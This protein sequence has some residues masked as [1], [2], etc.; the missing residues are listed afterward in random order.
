MGKNERE[1]REGERRKKS[2][3]TWKQS[4]YGGASDTMFHYYELWMHCG[5][6][7]A[8]F[9]HYELWMYGSMLTFI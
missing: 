5:A 1:K 2:S 4:E 7:D 9:D 3:N 8:M 6:S